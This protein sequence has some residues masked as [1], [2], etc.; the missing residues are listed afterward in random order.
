[1]AATIVIVILLAAYSFWVVRK[2]IKDIKNGK[3]C[4]GNC[5]GCQGFCGKKGGEKL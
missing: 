4:G 5:E 2:K 1:M 3:F